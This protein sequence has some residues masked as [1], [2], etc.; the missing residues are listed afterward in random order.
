[1]GQNSTKKNL[2]VWRR[3]IQNKPNKMRCSAVKHNSLLL[4][5]YCASKMIRQ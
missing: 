1:M 4:K 3:I 5:A 2:N